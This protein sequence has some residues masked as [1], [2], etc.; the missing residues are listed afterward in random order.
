MST[1]ELVVEG[2]ACLVC[3]R[4][5]PLNGH[6]RGGIMRTAVEEGTMSFTKKAAILKG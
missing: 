4:H 2:V 1:A 6:R 5:D 3:N